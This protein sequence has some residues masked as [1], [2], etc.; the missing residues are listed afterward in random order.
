M[1]GI[2]SG[3]LPSYTIEGDYIYDISLQ[4]LHRISGPSVDNNKPVSKQGFIKI[5]TILREDSS[6]PAIYLGRR[7]VK[8][9]AIIYIAH[10]SRMI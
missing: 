8:F 7:I 3:H 1:Q 2:G 9:C 6:S 5:L 10:M 4:Q